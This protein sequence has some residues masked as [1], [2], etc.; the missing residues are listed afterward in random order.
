MT[1]KTALYCRSCW[2]SICSLLLCTK[3]HIHL[4]VPTIFVP[5]P[6]KLTWLSFPYHPL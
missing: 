5:F 1:H 3:R 2:V 6:A 4:Q